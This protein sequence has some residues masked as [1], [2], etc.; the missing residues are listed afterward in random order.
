MFKLP[1]KA[2]S[3]YRFQKLEKLPESCPSLFHALG[4]LGAASKSCQ[5]HRY[6]LDG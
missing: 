3:T 1:N 6:F 4:F 5:R 2:G